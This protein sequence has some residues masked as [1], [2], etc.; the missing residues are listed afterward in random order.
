MNRQRLGM[1]D[2]DTGEVHEDGVLA[3][4]QPKRRNG[5]TDGWVAMAQSPMLELAK[6]DLGDAARRVLFAV[7]GRLD[8]ENWIV[9][10]QAELARLIGMK[11]SNFSRALKRLLDEKVLLAGPRTGRN[12]TYRLNPAYGWKG[13]AKAHR[14][15]VRDHLRVIARDGVTDDAALREEL[16]RAGQGRLLD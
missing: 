11:P 1:L 14:Q 13:S 15:A 10:P 2:L 8:F 7:L 16:E 3:Y 4:V 12:A 6:A 9:V 5:F